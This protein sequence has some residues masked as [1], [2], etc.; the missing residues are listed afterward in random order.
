MDQISKLLREFLWQ[1]GKGN[2]R[3]I[4]L[5]N[6][7]LVKRPTTEGV[8]QIHDPSLVN[9]ALG[10]KLLWKL[11]HEPKHPTNAILLSKYA[12]NSSFNNMQLEPPVNSSQDR[13]MGC[14]PLEEIEEIV[15]LRVWLVNAGINR[16]RD[17][18]VWDHQGDWAG[19]DLHDAHGWLSAQKNH[20][21]ELLEESMPENRHTKDSWAWGQTCVYSTAA[22]YKALQESRNK[23]HN[24]TFWKRVWDNLGLPKVNFFF[25]TLIHNKIF[26]GDNLEKRNIAGPH[27]CALCRSNQETTQHLF[28]DCHYAKEAWGLI[29]LG[30]Q[31]PPFPQCSI[32]DLFASWNMLYLQSIPIKS[33]W[34]KVWTAIP[35]F[36]CWQLWLARNEQIFNGHRLSP[37]L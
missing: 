20:L 14:D 19:W 13:I 29:L 30:L 3:K 5:V 17:L 15:E 33:F 4:H 37:L 26:T 22:G 25:W 1:G 23:N 11:V 8:L 27:R 16:L 24:P 18:S 12:H 31:I 9:L 34:N 28:L 36:V 35:K 2:E 32:A 6:W 7:D 10:G 21:I